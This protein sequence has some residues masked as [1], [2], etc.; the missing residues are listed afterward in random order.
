MNKLPAQL[1][2]SEFVGALKRRGLKQLKSKRGAAR[3][4]E[5]ASDGEI[6]TF[7]EPHGGGT[8]PPGTLSEYL[9][10]LELTRVEFE[11]LLLAQSE[12]LVAEEERYRR[13]SEPDGTIVSNCLKCFG[14]VGKSKTEAEVIAAEATHPCWLLPADSAPTV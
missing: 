10:K 6:F 7:H 8:I 1:R 12:P 14:I 9:R 3:Q 11:G 5:R 13:S 4:F 2:W